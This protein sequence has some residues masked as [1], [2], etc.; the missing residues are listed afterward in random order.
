MILLKLFATQRLLYTN[1]ISLSTDFFIFVT[2]LCYNPLL[3]PLL[4]PPL[5][6]QTHLV[7]V[8]S[9]CPLYNT[10]NQSKE[11]PPMP[12]ERDNKPVMAND[13]YLFAMRVFF[14]RWRPYII[15][16]IDFDGMTWFNR[17]PKQI[18]ITEKVLAELGKSICPLLEQI[19]DWS[20][21]AMKS[22]NMEIDPLGEM[23]HG[24]RERDETMMERVADHFAN[25]CGVAKAFG[26]DMVMLHGGHGWLLSQ[27]LSPLSNKRTDKWGGSLTNRARFPMLV[28]D[29]IRQEVG[30]DFLIEYR[31]SGDERV[32]GGCHQGGCQNPCGCRRR[33]QCTRTNRRS[34]RF[35]K[36]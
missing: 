25:A 36:M 30:P 34:H 16:A 27:F 32:P 7:L 29:H 8:I 24:Y 22:R 17:F 14:N 12:D 18:P 3:R 13:P 35:R 5:L 33:I 15:K 9:P 4:Q 28:L 31:V 23:W 11:E 10:D 19:Y 1:V 20:W 2:T 26:F 21:H 6:Q